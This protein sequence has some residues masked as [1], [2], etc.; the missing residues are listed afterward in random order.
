[1][2]EKGVCIVTRSLTM[3]PNRYRTMS[4]IA[5]RS[6]GL[7][8]A[9]TN[10]SEKELQDYLSHRVSWSTCMYHHSSRSYVF[11]C[12]FSH[13]TTPAMWLKSYS[14]SNFRFFVQLTQTILVGHFH[15]R[16]EWDTTS[17]RGIDCGSVGAFLCKASGTN[18]CEL[19]RIVSSI[20][21]CSNRT[22]SS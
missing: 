8:S 9:L 19:T 14:H 4:E 12:I 13:P 3:K 2:Q 21:F 17:E 16:Q 11:V 5:K 7:F 18:R 20:C 1:M 15:P 10:K 22:S 6:T